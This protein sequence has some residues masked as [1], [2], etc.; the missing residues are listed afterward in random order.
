MFSSLANSSARKI[1]YYYSNWLISNS[2]ARD[3][4]SEL[5]HRI[6]CLAFWLTKNR[7][8]QKTW[9]QVALNIGKSFH[10]LF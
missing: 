9:L 10:N 8:S 3:L 7:N 4:M 1:H 5:C 2:V 6:I